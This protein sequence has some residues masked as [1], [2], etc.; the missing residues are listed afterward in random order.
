MGREVELKLEIAPGDARR[1]RRQPVLAA[2]EAHRQEQQS[3]YFDTRGMKL[4]RNGLVL[5]V[6]QVGREFVQTVKGEGLFDRSEWEAPV[7]GLRPEPRAAAGTPLAGLLGADGFAKLKPV[8][9]SEVRRTR[10]ELERGDTR[11]ELVLDQGSVCAGDCKQPISEI[12]LELVD[13]DPAIIF[14]IA[15][16]L[17]ARIPLRLEVLSKAERGFAL[18]DGRLGKVTKAPPLELAPGMTAGE[19]F[20]AI[21]LSC[22]T[23]FRLNEPLVVERRDAAALHQSRVAMRR[24]RSAFS[25]FAPIIRD[26]PGFA[27]LRDELRWFTSELGEARNLDVFLKRPELQPAERVKLE[28]AREAQYEAI[29]AVLASSRF[30]TLMLDLAAWILTGDWRQR[31]RAGKRLARFTARRIDRLWDDIEIRG[32]DLASLAEEPRHRLRIDI[33]KIRYALEFV[34][35]LH[36]GAGQKRKRFG[37]AL[38]GLQETLG[39]LNDMATARAIAASHLA[40]KGGEWAP[41]GDDDAEAARHLAEASADFARLAKVGAYWRSG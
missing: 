23:H 37:A 1:L 39:H 32:G 26:D 19:G 15:R 36:R 4:R 27:P 16:E 14:A 31:R 33:K 30:R 9:R 7:A 2:V 34:A 10:W 12:E 20:A 18:A 3:V 22:L 13:G 21:A 38:G 41:T 5:R 28:A 6:R 25:L 29:V 40:G 24:L 11:V 17:G 35:A 8:V